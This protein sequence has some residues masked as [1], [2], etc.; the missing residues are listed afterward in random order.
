[1]HESLVIFLVNWDVQ[2]SSRR[3]LPMVGKV[4]KRHPLLMLS[5]HCWVQ[6]RVEAKFDTSHLEAKH[7]WGRGTTHRSLSLMTMTMACHVLYSLHILKKV[8]HGVSIS[9]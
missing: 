1:M 3:D 6:V 9:F 7:V 4:Y 5:A 2:T 8:C